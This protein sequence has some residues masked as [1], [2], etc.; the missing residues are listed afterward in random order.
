MITIYQAAWGQTLRSVCLNDTLIRRRQTHKRYECTRSH[1]LIQTRCKTFYR[2]NYTHMQSWPNGHAGLGMYT[3]LCIN[4]HTHT[5]R[6]TKLLQRHAHLYPEW[7]PAFAVNASLHTHTRTH[8]FQRWHLEW[9][10]LSL[11]VCQPCII[12]DERSPLPLSVPD[13]G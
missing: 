7:H 9:L 13:T 11:T 2:H 12:W 8:W 4:T 1:M 3:Q 6:E 5:E 10:L